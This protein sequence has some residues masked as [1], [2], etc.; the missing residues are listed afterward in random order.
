MEKH[1]ERSD[2]SP[3]PETAARLSPPDPRKRPFPVI[4]VAKGGARE[5]GSPEDLQTRGSSPAAT[6]SAQGA[7]G[8]KAWGEG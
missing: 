1:A 5:G 8:W 2:P 6:P 7:S 4:L 3:L